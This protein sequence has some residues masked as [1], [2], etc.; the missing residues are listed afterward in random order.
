[1]SG[2]ATVISRGD[3]VGLYATIVLSALGIGLAAW[4]AVA[5]LIE[6]LPGRDVPVTVPFPGET[7]TLPIGPDGAPLEVAVTE[8]TV[9]VPSPAAATFFALVAEPIVIGGAVVAGI[10]LLAMLCWNLARGRAFT[11]SS[12]R[13]VFTGAGVLT[14]GWFIGGMLTNMTVNGAL[15]AVSEYTYDGIT[16]GTNFTAVFGI[17][18]LGAL[19]AAFQVGERLQRDTEGLV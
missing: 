12:V 8:A 14:A 18:A 17:L 2:T 3:R 4:A 9:I 5:R 19:G 1:M 15:S 13:I 11:R 10:V 6:V 16:F 7:A